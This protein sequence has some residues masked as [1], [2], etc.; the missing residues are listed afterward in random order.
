MIFLFLENSNLFD[1]MEKVE[2]IDYSPEEL[3]DR[4]LWIRQ[5]NFAYDQ[6]QQRYTELDDMTPDEWYYSNQKARN[7]YIKPRIN[8]SDVRIVTGI[9]REKTN[10]IV[11]SLLN[12]NLEGDLMSFDEMNMPQLEYSRVVSDKI[13]QSRKVESPSYDVKRAEY[14][15]ELGTQGDVWVLEEWVEQELV[16]KTMSE[17]VVKDVTKAKWTTRYDYPKKYCNSRL[18]CGLNVYLG[19]IRQRHVELQPYIVLREEITRYEAESRYKS[20]ERWKNVPY[21]IS[22]TV[23]TSEGGINNTINNWTMVEVGENMVEVLYCFNKWTNSYQLMLNGIPMLP[24]GFPLE[25]LLGVCEYPISHGWLEPIPFFALSRSVPSKTKVSQA[26]MD[27]MWKCMILKT[28]KSY[29]PSLANNTGQVL[30]ERIFDAGW[31]QNNIDPNKLQP[32]G[33]NSGVSG[34]EYQMLVEIQK[35]IDQASVTPLFQGQSPGS[36]LTATQIIEQKQQQLMNLGITMV[37]VINLEISMLW[38]RTY[39]ILKHWVQEKEVVR[40]VDGKLKRV[41]EYEQDVMD[42]EFEDGE[43]GMRIVEFMDGELPESEQVLAEEQLLTKKFGLPIRKIY[44]NREELEDL[45]YRYF[46]SVVPTERNSSELRSALYMDNLQKAFGLFGPQSIN[47]EYAKKRWA[48]YQKEDPTK[49]FLPPT[50]MPMGGI[51]GLVNGVSGEGP[52][53]GGTQKSLIDEILPRPQKRPS[54]LDLAAS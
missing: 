48:N 15:D 40:T 18:I 17:R 39:N 14:Y 9:T 26:M 29:K 28:R 25:Y 10:T 32:I 49:F 38:L 44:F 8:P 46:F 1:G 4:A 52:G 53:S 51:E 13:K 30:T 45:K 41:M 20:Y 7:A 31:I 43:S 37:G 33:D 11:S 16:K 36:K 21:A 5:A 23:S 3:E 42:A 35:F 34:T 24:V 2:P 22:R 47:L 27:E 50:Q 54:L 19:N 12:Y 6:R